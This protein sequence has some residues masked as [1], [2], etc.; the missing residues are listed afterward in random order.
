MR[1]NDREQVQGIKGAKFVC[2]TF[3][4]DLKAQMLSWVVVVHVFNSRAQKAEA[5]G[6]L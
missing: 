5:G 3:L 1:L 2:S 4:E 6:S